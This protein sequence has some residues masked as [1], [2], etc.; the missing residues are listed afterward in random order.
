MNNSRLFYQFYKAISLG[1]NPGADKHSYK[2]DRN[3]KTKIFSYADRRNIIK[4]T[5]QLCKFLSENYIYLNNIKDI[6]YNH[7]N[8]FFEY[9]S[10][11]S[12]RTLKN[13]KYCIKKLQKLVREYLY[14][15]VNYIDERGGEFNTIECL[16]MIDMSKEDLDI[17]LSEC[18][19]SKSKAGIGIEVAVLFGLRVSEICKLKAK[20]I[21]LEKMSLIVF[22]GKGKRSR[23]IRINS[24]EQLELCIRIK[25]KYEEND[26]VCPLKED[27][28][29]AAIRRMLL[30]NKITVYKEHFTGVH[31]IRK[32]YAKNTYEALL[33]QGYEERVAWD[34]TANNLGHG[35]DRKALKNVYIRY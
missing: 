17:L 6:N 19:K 11:C 31:A 5:N 2:R 23:A 33:S 7:I 25:K 32:S 21:D 16:R 28:V 12:C 20:D 1:F 30:K 8:K 34:K 27:S 24:L 15:K 35:K 26:R 13:Y 22:E 14:I 9:K 18:K 4:V 3:K 10:Y 29:N